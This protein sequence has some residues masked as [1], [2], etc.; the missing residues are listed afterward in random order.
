M[1]I[2]DCHDYPH[3]TIRRRKTRSMIDN[4]SSWFRV[5]SGGNSLFLSIFEPVFRIS[6]PGYIFIFRDKTRTVSPNKASTSFG[7]FQRKSVISVRDDLRILYWFFFDI[8]WFWKW[9]D[10]RC[11][12][13]GYWFICELNW[14]FFCWILSRIWE[15]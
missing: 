9:F 10:C 14:D 2:I 7:H 13:L 8:L 6:S 5:I 1:V 4:N 15:Q 11:N 12:W 3:M